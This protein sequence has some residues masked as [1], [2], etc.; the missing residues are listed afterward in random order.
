MSVLVVQHLEP[1]RPAVL[2]EALSAAGLDVE[3]VRVDLG[4]DLPATAAGLDG[5]VV[6]GGPM[7]AS[8]DDGFPSRRAELDLIADALERGTPTLGV[9]L[10]AQ[11]IAVAA[12]A[13]IS[14]GPAPE[15][16][17]GTIALTPEID[18]DPL[19]DGLGAE[20]TVLHWHGETFDLPAGAVLL[21]STAAYLNQAFRLG[22]A[23]GF[24]FHLEVDAPAV[25]RFVVAFPED[26]AAAPG[27]A[28]GIRRDADRSLARLAEARSLVLARFAGRCGS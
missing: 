7:S 18:D 25:E 19:L 23:W 12:G 11:M 27:G 14:R 24:Q 22:S 26:A 1:E 21:G 4:A 3:L 5:L 10:G 15:I 9:C 28:A 2:G 20:L 17:W 6:L 13:P 16:G 8:S